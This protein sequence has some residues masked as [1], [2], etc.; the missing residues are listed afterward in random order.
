MIG[1]DTSTVR[2]KELVM[3][4]NGNNAGHFDELQNGDQIEIYW[5][6]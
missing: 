6:S 3:T 4:L 5:R 2:G 1:F